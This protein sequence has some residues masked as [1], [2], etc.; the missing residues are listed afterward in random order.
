[1]NYD[2]LIISLEGGGVEGGVY[3]ENSD[4]LRKPEWWYMC[5]GG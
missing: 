3:S 5:A 1:M 2:L 4:F